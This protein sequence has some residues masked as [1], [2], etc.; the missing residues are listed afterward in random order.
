MPA[1]LH[2]K[3]Y[4]RDWQLKNKDKCRVYK[5]RWYFKN[6]ERISKHRQDNAEKQR[7]YSR[8]WYKRNIGKRKMQRKNYYEKNKDSL[9]SRARQW[10]LDHKELVQQRSRDSELLRNF[11]LTRQEYNRI[12]QVQGGMCKI[13]GIHQ[14]EIN[15][16][17]RVDHCH[18]TNK[19]RGLLC[20]NCN[21]TLGL[22]KENIETLKKMIEYIGG[23]I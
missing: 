6:I 11:G 23:S 4:I 16:S 8:E 14:E 2:R 22:I 13:C 21:V 17:L 7:E 5:Q 18:K 15:K 3:E 19:V 20:H 12:F 9:N 1:I 10:Y